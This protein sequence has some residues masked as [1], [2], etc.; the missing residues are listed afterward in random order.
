M[1]ELKTTEA[2]FLTI[3]EVFRQQKGLILTI[4]LLCSLIFKHKPIYQAQVLIKPA[5]NLLLNLSPSD[6]NNKK[7]Y[8]TIDLHDLFT[9]CISSIVIKDFCYEE[10]Y[11]P[12]LSAVETQGGSLKVYNK[13]YNLLSV[14]KD[15]ATKKKQYEITVTA[16]NPD[17]ALKRLEQFIVY[18]N[19]KVNALL[20]LL[21]TNELMQKGINRITQA[22]VPLI[23]LYRKDYS[24]F[25]NPLTFTPIIN[26]YAYNSP[27]KLS[28]TIINEP[29]KKTL[30]LGG[31]GGLL[32]GF[33]AASLRIGIARSHR[34]VNN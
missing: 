13:F 23:E 16:D 28:N 29:L 5:K 33:F 9:L 4:T 19:S 15:Y 1:S 32:L 27:E 31:S 6:I 12:D 8:S 22:S 11:L 30:I 7:N 24:V 21:W 3:S 10:I 26:F 20:E 14:R 17:K 18:I 2:S 34:G 25:M